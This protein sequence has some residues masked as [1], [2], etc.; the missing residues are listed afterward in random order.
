[1]FNPGGGV[2]NPDQPGQ[3]IGNAL[4]LGLRT[5]ITF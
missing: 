2:P 5:V 3:R 4:V 1:V